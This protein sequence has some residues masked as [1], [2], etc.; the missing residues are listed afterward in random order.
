MRK[1]TD[2]PLRPLPANAIRAIAIERL[3]ISR[4]PLGLCDLGVV[5]TRNRSG[6][7]LHLITWAMHYSREAVEL[8]G[9]HRFA[10]VGYVDWIRHGR[11]CTEDAYEELL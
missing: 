5:R 1:I 11:V 10:W 7:R 2:K 3:S 6:S 4:L 9:A 8:Y